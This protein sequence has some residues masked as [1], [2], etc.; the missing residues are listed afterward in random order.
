M[1]GVCSSPKNSSVEEE[2]AG[3]QI[4][5]LV[6]KA[7]GL[8]ADKVPL[9]DRNIY[10]SVVSSG[11]DMGIDASLTNVIDPVFNCEFDTQPGILEFAVMEQVGG[12]DA[13][14]LG[15]ATLDVSTLDSYAGELALEGD[16]ASGAVLI[17]KVK[18]EAFEYPE[19]ASMSDY[20]VT[21]DNP[22][23][24]K[25]FGLELDTTDQ[26]CLYLS[27]VKAKGFIDKHNSKAEE[28][29]KLQAGA[30]IVAYNGESGDAPTIESSMKKAATTAEFTVRPTEKFRIAI[31]KSAGTTLGVDI[32]K[33]PVG[34][35][36]LI[37]NVKEDGFVSKWN[38]DHPEQQVKTG[39]RIIEVN[40]KKGKA[41]EIIDMVKK[42]PKSDRIV[43]TIIRMAVQ[44]EQ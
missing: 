16:S 15:Q 11:V 28:S 43:L 6:V 21:V 3:P 40:G 22:K 37:L 41:K 27:H 36:V 9:D 10:L 26:T 35:S 29:N 39:D 38:L 19:D 7:M 33:T 1:G 12:S 25:T 18:A 14:R 13:V 44:P 24:T 32:P 23:K 31:D 4:R 17:V 20:T 5:V 34:T 8:P 42:A 2:T 30:F